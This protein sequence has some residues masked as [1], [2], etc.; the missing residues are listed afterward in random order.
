MTD[1][2]RLLADIATL[3]TALNE[4]GNAGCSE[5]MIYIAFG[6]DMSRYNGCANVCK[7]AG[8]ITISGNF[9]KLTNKGIETAKQ[10][11]KTLQA[12]KS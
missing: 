11:E 7:Q 4:T 8:F 5:S 9:V 3:L 10:L 2:N 12:S 6:L 1:R